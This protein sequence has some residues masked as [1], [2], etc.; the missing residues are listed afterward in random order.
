VT[1]FITDG[2]GPVTKNDNAYELAAHYLR[3]LGID[4]GKFFSVVSSYDDVLAYAF[5]RK[6]YKAGNTLRLILP[7]LKAFGATDQGIQTYSKEN[8][9]L[10]PGAK[11]TLHFVWRALNLPAYIISTS[12]EPYVK[13]FCATIGFP[14]ESTYCTW[15]RIDDYSITDAEIRRLKELSAEIAAMNVITMTENASRLEDF[16]PADR[17]AISRLETI[18]WKELPEMSIYQI[19]EDTDPVGGQEKANAITDILARTGTI[20]PEAMYVGDSITDIEALRMVR[21]G[22]GLAVS[23]NGNSY[24]VAEADIAVLSYDT[25]VTSLLT[26]AF[27]KWGTERVMGIVEEWGGAIRKKAGG[28][29]PLIARLKRLDKKRL[30]GLYAVTDTNRSLITTQSA[31]FRKTVRGEGIGG[32][33]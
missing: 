30:A 22:G 2:E 18:F 7:F 6:N 14:F 1:V 28:E 27:A 5:K 13:A 32:L 20:L 4:G 23:F 3:G 25:E 8:I 11:E 24:A 17:N 16:A 29:D 31:A 33:G 21:E 12:Y 19:V 15:L 9:L 26:E 10:M